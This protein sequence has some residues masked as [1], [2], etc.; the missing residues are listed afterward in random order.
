MTPRGTPRPLV[1]TQGDPDGVGPDLLLYAASRGHLSANDVVFAGRETLAQRAATI[2]NDW[3]KRG[4]AAI[5]PLLAPG[6]TKQNMGQFECL[7]LAVDEVLARVDAALVTAPIDKSIAAREG[8]STPGHTEYL[9]MRSG[10]E[11][12]AMLMA[13]PRLR[14]ILATIH[15]A[16]RDVPDALSSELIVQNS[17]LLVRGLM[18]MYGCQRPSI[19]ILGLN[20]HA[21]E[22]GN[23]GREDID[24]IAPAIEML[25]KQFGD[26][27]AFFGP[28]PADTAFHQHIEGRYDGLVAMY[29]DQGLAPF[30]LMHFHDGVN[31]TLGLPFI[32]TSPDHG[33]AKDIVG[34]PAVDPRSFLAAIELAR[35]VKAKAT[36]TTEG[37]G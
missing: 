31:V 8:L 32:R 12:F 19:G 16:L 29:H 21:G 24:V 35:G 33:T 3:A 14:V 23:F 6:I 36:S 26:R 13:G 20:P 11:A 10:V 7:R 1:L 4:L 22:G 15:I 5:D 2:G 18:D 25:R 37:L 34:T 27:A 9:A 28:L 17:G 30:K